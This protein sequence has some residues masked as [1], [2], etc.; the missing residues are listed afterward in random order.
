MSGYFRLIGSLAL[1]AAV[2]LSGSA[3]AYAA[4]TPAAAI[5][6]VDPPTP[7]HDWFDSGK[8]LATGGVSEIEGSAG[9]G[10]TPWALIAGYGTRDAIGANIHETYVS[11]PGFTLNTSGLAVGLFDRVE[12]SYARQWFDTDKTGGKLGLGNNYTFHMDIY[13]AKVKLAGD[14]VYGQDRW[15]PQIALGAQYKVNDRRALLAAI[16]ARDN[17]GADYYLSATKLLL[18]QSLLINATLRETKANQTGIL[19]FG[20][21]SDSYKLQAEGSAAYLISRKFAIGGEYRMKP[22]NLGF[23]REDDWADIFVAWFPTK[24]ISVTAAY[25][26]LGEIALQDN[27]NGAYLSVQVGF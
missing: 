11:L 21:K 1:L 10:L 12:L 8:L 26:A 25:A 24:N 15:L 2:T 5:E 20:G 22:D 17:E 16:G 6:D 7:P 27:Q 9:G 13:G 14:A 18:A 23:A 4:D 19:G 3:A